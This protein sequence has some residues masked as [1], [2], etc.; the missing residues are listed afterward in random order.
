M[1]KQ[2]LIFCF[3]VYCQGNIQEIKQETTNSCG[4]N[5]Q[6]KINEDKTTIEIIITKGKIEEK[7]IN[8]I[9]QY[10]DTINTMILQCE[11]HEQ[12]RQFIHQFPQL[13][14]IRIET[15]KRIPKG[16]FSHL[17]IETINIGKEVEIIEERAFEN[18]QKLTKI[19]FEESQ[20]KEIRDYAFKE[21]KY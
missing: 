4:D 2:I 9:L 21:C 18:C 17:Q 16:I 8:K 12:D 19:T 5:C 20:V 11:L 1:I 3:V 6:Y 7:E 13:K 14:Q 10:K 15:T